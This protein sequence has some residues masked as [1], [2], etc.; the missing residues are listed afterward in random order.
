MR[1]RR[2]PVINGMKRC[3][4]CEVVK[5]IS[6][7]H[8]ANAKT[9]GR[10]AYCR[11]CKAAYAAKVRVRAQERGITPEI[12]AKF[13]A[14]VRKDVPGPLDTPCWIWTGFVRKRDGYGQLWF[15][16]KNTAPHLVSLLLHGRSAPPNEPFA[17]H[18]CRTPLCCNPEHLRYVT[19]RVNTLE[20]NDNFAAVN[21][22]KTHH[23]CGRPFAGENL[24]LYTNPSG[25]VQRICL[26]C[27]P[28]FWRYALIPRDPPPSA[29]P[30]HWRVKLRQKRV[31]PPSG[32][33]E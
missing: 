22:R 6:E 12:V 11:P 27:Q 31:S 30:N 26:H 23:K 8:V 33:T 28:A 7:Y 16:G 4:I 18:M 13:W 29:H 32:R 15:A 3:P 20:N 2:N 24:A 25:V 9:G 17:D 5:P 1:A 19:P 14:R 21:A 10:G